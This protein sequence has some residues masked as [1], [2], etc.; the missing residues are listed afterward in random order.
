MV[1]NIQAM[2]KTFHHSFAKLSPEWK[3]L[4]AFIE[5]GTFTFPTPVKIGIDKGV[6]R[7]KRERTNTD[8]DVFAQYIPISETL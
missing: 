1:N 8:D 3:R 5:N 2:I 6:K 4:Q 7:V